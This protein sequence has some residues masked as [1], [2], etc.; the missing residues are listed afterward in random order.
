MKIQTA[1]TQSKKKGKELKSNGKR[2][3]IK[4]LSPPFAIDAFRASTAGSSLSP[5]GVGSS[6]VGGSLWGSGVPSP[7]APMALIGGGILGERE[8]KSSKADLATGQPAPLQRGPTTTTVTLQEL[9]QPPPI[10]II[11]GAMKIVKRRTA[12]AV[13]SRYLIN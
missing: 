8:T 13:V 2:R 7:T 5:G 12:D 3:L 4:I 9:V 1:Q 6:G 11:S 10:W